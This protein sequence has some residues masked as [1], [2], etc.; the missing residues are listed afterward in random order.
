MVN[1]KQTKPKVHAT[2]KTEELLNISDYVSKNYQIIFKKD[3][4]CPDMLNTFLH[5]QVLVLY[6]TVVVFVMF[7][8]H[9]S[10]P[11]SKGPEI[12]I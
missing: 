5:H 9:I 10:L 1:S 3:F 6:A 2:L 7:A 11:I 12:L 4:E 8:S